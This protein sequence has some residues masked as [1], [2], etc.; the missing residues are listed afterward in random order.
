MDCEDAKCSH[1]AREGEW[2]TGFRESNIKPEGFPYK[3]KNFLTSWVSV[4]FWR[5]N[6]HQQWHNSPLWAKAFLRSFCH[7]SLFIAALLQCWRS[8]THWNKGQVNSL[9]NVNRVLPLPNTNVS[10]VAEGKWFQSTFTHTTVQYCE[11]FNLS[12]LGTIK[13]PFKLTKY[14]LI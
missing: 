6:H 7:P 14:T 2:S 5:S 3:A 4:K 11:G 1:V 13:N 10:I 8:N 9:H 12:R